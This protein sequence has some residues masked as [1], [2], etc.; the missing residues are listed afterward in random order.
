MRKRLLPFLMLALT[1]SSLWA[2]YIE[3]HER[4]AV[5]NAPLTEYADQK[6][7]LFNEGW[8]F[9]LG[10]PEGAE[11]LDFDDSAW[12]LLDLPHDYQFE[13][14]WERNEDPGRGFKRMCEGWYRKSFTLPEHLKNRRVVLDFEGVMYVADVYVNGQ[15]VASNEY[16]YTGFEA[17]ISKALNWG[18]KNVVA[19]YSSTG[20]KNGS[21]WYTGGGIYRNV[22]LRVGNETR[23]SRHGLYIQTQPAES[24]L[25]ASDGEGKSGSWTVLA[26]VQV[27]RWQ[28][29]NIY[30]Y[31]RA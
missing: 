14:P 16:G 3:Q 2:Q 5:P 23:I 11:K 7:Q 24:I 20:P 29:H 1:S 6:C 4:S 18:G 21:R 27:E 17:D 28:K 19:V 31:V 26:Q 13:Q 10:N 30:I 9:L 22:W 15:L 8:R 12:R 25:P